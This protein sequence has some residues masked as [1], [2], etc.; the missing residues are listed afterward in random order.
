MEW[1]KVKNIII[2]ILLALN[3]ILLFLAAGREYE[4]RRYQEKARTEVL[5]TMAANGVSLKA[6]VLPEDAVLPALQLERESMQ[7]EPEQ[8]EALLGPCRRE[9][10]SGG[11][12]VAYT[13]EK[14]RMDAFSSG[15]FT[16]EFRS[17]T[18]VLGDRDAEAYGAG[19][20]EQLGCESELV[21]REEDDGELRLTFRQIWGGI[22]VFNCES[23]LTY[24]DGELQRME[25]RR[26]CGTA[27]A[28]SQEKMI[29]VPTLLIRFLSQRNESGRMFS[30]I[31]HIEA[32][33]QAASVRPFS[34]MP[35]WYIETDTGAYILSGTDGKV[36]D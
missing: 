24:R 23:H 15:R 7:F 1:S 30:K 17:G 5:T 28:A 36:L 25:G 2:L 6:D 20:L 34:L 21:A 32:G 16:V 12:R 22:P 4:Y 35:V 29:T 14:G 11:I 27:A 26:L 8:V 31:T 9:D 13:G 18:M 10:E 3:G 19:V 33:Y